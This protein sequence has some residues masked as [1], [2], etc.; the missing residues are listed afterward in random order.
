M[1]RLSGKVALITGGSRGLGKGIALRLSRAG[2]D[3]AV[4]GYDPYDRGV[5]TAEEVA[6]TIRDTGRRAIS[7]Q[8]DISNAGAIDAVVADV[9]AH[10]GRID[11]LVT[12][13]GLVE[14]T[15][16]FD[17]SVDKWD[18][19]VAVTLSGTFF[20]I[21]AVVPRMRAQG[22]GKI[23]TIS[24]DAAK[25]GGLMAGPHY[26]AAKGGILGLMRGL[27]RQL[28]PHRI[29]VNDVCPADIPVERWGDKK[30]EDL[31][32]IL[33]GIPLGRFGSPDDIGAAVE[34]LASDDANHITGVSLNVTGGAL[35][36]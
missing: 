13:A 14:H 22:G 9:L 20:A 32:A 10:F 1:E 34:F 6:A 15:S 11:I 2:A 23:I 26:C 30:S 33:R 35:I 4:H 31:Q 3:V 8:A 36:D 21:R 18:R 25:R 5:S 24:S 12:C 7:V 28:G 19:M 16:V 29:N 27:A 17:L